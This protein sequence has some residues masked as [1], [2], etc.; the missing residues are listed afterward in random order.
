MIMG[1]KTATVPELLTK[2]DKILVMTRIAIIIFRSVLAN[3]VT[4]AAILSQTPVSNKALP[5]IITPI[6]IRMVLLANPATAS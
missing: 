3:S 1:I 5:T 2:A 4:L 6:S